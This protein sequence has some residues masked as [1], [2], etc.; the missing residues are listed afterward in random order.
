[1]P[2]PGLELSIGRRTAGLGSLGRPRWVAVADWKG[3]PLVR[4]AKAVVPSAWCRAHDDADAR[5]RCGDIAGGRY[6][7][8]DPWHAVA[9]GIVVRR[10]SPNNRKIEA[11]DPAMQTLSERLLAAMGRE[12][13]AVHLGVADRS[14]AILRD[15]DKRDG[16]DWLA[17]SAR[18]DGQ[19]HP[20][21]LQGLP[22]QLTQHTCHPG[23]CRRQISQG[24][25]SSDS[26]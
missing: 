15:L 5:I 1:M 21:R 14:Q 11:D 3:G 6:R 23:I 10:L 13:A 9:D 26:A 2:E 20:R 22:Q 19:S 7:A 4:E 25:Q 8:P 12:L 16:D 24:S 18:A 17:D